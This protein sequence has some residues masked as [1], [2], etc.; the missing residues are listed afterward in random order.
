MPT[1]RVT[2]RSYYTDLKAVITNAGGSA[3]S[4]ISFNGEPDILFDLIGREW[5]VSVKIGETPALLKSAF[6]QYQRH[7]EHSARKH[8][9]LL[10]LPE[11]ARTIPARAERITEAVGRMKVA[12]LVDTPLVKEEFRDTSFAEVIARLVRE[13]PPRLE[14]EE[15]TAYPLSLVIALLQQHVTELMQSIRMSNTA[16]LRIITDKKLLSGLGH[17][18]AGQADEVVHFLAAYILL[19]QMLFLRLFSAAQAD[20]VPP[21]ARPVTAARLR[22]AFSKILEI[23]YRPI[24]EVEVVGL[25]PAH[26][27]ADT[28]DLISGLEVERSRYE[29]P[30]RIFHELMPKAIRKMLAAFYTRPQAAELLSRLTIQD[31]HASVFDPACGSGTILAAAYRRKR[32]LYERASPGW[33]PHKQFCEQE[34]FGADI[35]PFAVHLASANLAAMDPGTTIE[36]TQIIQGDSL[37]LALGHHY[38]GGLQVGL[39]PT[40]RTARRSSGEEYEVN[41][42]AV[43]TLLMNPPFTKVE[44][45]IAEY[46]DMKRFGLVSGGEVGLWGHFIILADEFL[47]EGATFGGVVPIS[48]LRGRESTKVREFLFTNWTLLYILKS[49]HNYGFSEW[50]EYRDVLL[51]ARKGTPPPGHC[52]KVCLIKQGIG[53]LTQVDIERIATV[54]L[55][56]GDVRGPA[57]DSQSFSIDELKARFPN[58]MWFVGVSDLK[59]RDTLVGFVERFEGTLGHFPDGY[60]REGYR[61]VPKG[62]SSFLFLTRA[63]DPS[64]VE[65]AFLQ[66]ETEGRR[67]II[68]RSKMGVKYTVERSALAPTLRTGI[69]LTSMSI[70][71]RTDYA[72]VSSYGELRR[73]VRA[74]GFEPPED[75]SWSD[76]WEN[77]QR[78][79]EAVKTR[80]VVAHRINPFSPSTYMTAFYSDTPF[81]PS[82]VLNV[83]VEPDPAR[84]KAV[85]VLLNSA[86]F[87]AQ[88]FLLKEETTGRYINLRFYDLAQM[89]L[90]PGETVVTNLVRVF[91][92]FADKR[93]P[94]LRDQLD[95]L[96]GHRYSEY[97]DKV[98]GG[99]QGRLFSVAREPVKSSPLRIAFDKAVCEALSVRISEE[100]LK[101]IYK[102]IV[103]EMIVTRGLQRD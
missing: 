30:G 94:C 97:W 90:Y 19:S 47:K 29:L 24:Y 42:G 2:E 43:D 14:R 96:F 91:D 103:K 93:F 95:T 32:E 100:E 51:I 58:M 56:E 49:T 53:S 102:V 67:E 11:A 20:R 82:N 18:P 37:E 27:L 60:F 65:E 79:F 62:V 92:R 3:V 86:L 46:V 4:E 5:V 89:A 99:G 45:G 80:L 75:F 28:Y 71:G 85:C 31:A 101:E 34:I 6:I 98:R 54:A 77:V 55:R 68:A 44:R 74:S 1:G 59:H 9:L 76:F 10:L 72:A 15:R 52:V 16:M 57:F 87:L 35:M 8:G 13:L 66:F 36:S 48:I 84:A 61:P 81:S 88:F 12:C 73:V 21:P 69:G 17:L 38:P 26:Y 70:E 7:K 64:R 23:N 33:N 41:L 40:A 25:V 22:A 50:S 83:V 63:V 39:F 78:E